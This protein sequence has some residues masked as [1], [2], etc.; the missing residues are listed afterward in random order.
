MVVDPVLIRVLVVVHRAV[1]VVDGRE[2]IEQVS[3]VLRHVVRMVVREVWS[4]QNGVLVVVKGLNVVLVV[5]LVIKLWVVAE[6]LV[7][8]VDAMELVVVVSVVHVLVHS[9]VM[10]I[11]LAV[12]KRGSLMV[13]DVMLVG[14]VYI[15]RFEDKLVSRL[16]VLNRLVIVVDVFMLVVVHRL[17]LIDVLLVVDV[18]DGLLVVHVVHWLLPDEMFVLVVAR[19]S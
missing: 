9:E 3:V 8:V 2:A 14:L 19:L 4:V 15:Q 18:T 16:V 10:V 13:V 17:L 1:V 11:L 6:V 12:G 7:V 5:P